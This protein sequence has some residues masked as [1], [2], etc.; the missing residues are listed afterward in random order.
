VE[1][2]VGTEQAIPA[3][4][5]ATPPLTGLLAVALRDPL[6]ADVVARSGQP[7]NRIT[8]PVGLRPFVTAALAA[9]AAVG[10]AGV[11]V[12]LVTATGREAE[13]AAAAISDLIG[14]DRV[15]TFPSWETLPHE[16][17]SPAADTVGRRV[18]VLRR[19]AHPEEHQGGLPA[20][21]V[22]TI[23]SLVQ[24]MAPDLG[25]MAPVRLELG[26]AAGLGETVERLV[27]LAYHRVELVER[28]GEIAV[29][30]GILDIFAT[31]AAHPVRVEFF[32][33]EIVDMRTFA[34]TDQRSIEQV[35]DLV[36][37]P[38][39]EILLTDEVRERAAEL[40]V[41]ATGDP[42]LTEMVGKIAAGVP[43]EGMESLIPALL[44]GRLVL[45]P[46]LLPPGTVVVLADPERIRTRADDLVRTGQEFL[47]ASWMA[48]AAGGQAPIDLG[49][50]AYR[51]LDET[52]DAVEDLGLSLWRLAPF[53]GDR[54]GAI[55]PSGDPSIEPAALPAPSYRG[56]V[57]AAVAD[58]AARMADGG[59]TVVV[60]A[61]PGTAGRAIEILGEQGLGAHNA[62]DGI[63]AEPRREVVTVGCGRLEDGVILTASNLAIV[64][65]SDL[66]GNRGGAP[67]A[68]TKL[69]GRRRNA[70]DPATLQPGDHVVHAQHGIGRYV[71]M[72]QRQSGGATRDYLVVEYAPGKRGQPGDRLYVPTDAL[73]LLSRYVGGEDS[74]AEQARRIGLGQ[75]QGPGAQGRPAD[76]RQAGVA[77]RGPGQRPGSCLRPRHPVAA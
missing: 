37:P 71:Q 74:D 55:D 40:T 77:L 52:L 51:P 26:D 9:P 68:A 67:E 76:R 65:E 48:A 54:S 24:P 12:C 3:G 20:V 11:R 45:L 73:D 44:P 16:R 13:S 53:A 36:A 5:A 17:L 33:D 25:E 28:R 70:I 35:V 4:P 57:A 58:A 21:I 22:T 75:D 47:A 64:T 14:A 56:Q 62:A 43:V 31:T 15:V 6:L 23:R 18:S 41:A 34:V 2:D 30:G 61:G 27:Q 60:V 72:V 10:G 19:L 46:E 49:E 1:A 50:S 59:T 38:C 42:T 29:R 7:S 8:G 39:R 69:P 32:G 66:T 63:I